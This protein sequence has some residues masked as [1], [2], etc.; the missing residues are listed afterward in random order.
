MT[1]PTLFE[2]ALHP[3]LPIALCTFYQGYMLANQLKHTSEQIA[4]TLANA[5]RPLYLLADV[6]Q[7]RLEWTDLLNTLLNIRDIRNDQTT[8]PGTLGLLVVTNS[9]VIKMGAKAL[10]QR[11]YSPTS[12]VS[13]FESLEDAYAF[14]QT[15]ISP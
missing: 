7:L 8:R 15:Q 10:T 14:V 13:V 11:Q 4:A 3:D 12:N 9:S 2:I 5:D 6:R 1:D